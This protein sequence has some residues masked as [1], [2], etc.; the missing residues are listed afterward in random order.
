MGKTAA[1]IFESAYAQK[2]Y[3]ALIGEPT[4]PARIIH[5]GIRPEEFEP[6]T[7][8]ANAADFVFVGELRELKGIFPL[9]EA[10]AGMPDA[11]LVM[12]GD[13]ADRVA[14]EA[15]IAELG[16]AER[17]KLVGSQPARQVFGMG[18]CV[19]V[20]SLA[21]SLPYI[22]LEAAAAQLPVIATNVGGIPEIFGP[23]AGSLVKANNAQALQAAMKRFLASPDAAAAEMRLRLDHIRAGFSVARM[24]DQ[25]EALYLER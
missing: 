12:A 9:V 13:G 24:T 11:R 25:I 14:L 23:T 15:K 2:T 16:I 7:P 19:I 3:A 17:V 8:G 4:C 5:N 22:V 20:P 1:I 10:L 6:V 21:E 18:R